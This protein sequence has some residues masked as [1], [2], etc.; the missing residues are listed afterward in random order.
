MQ[1]VNLRTYTSASMEFGI[2]NIDEAVEQ[3][4]EKPNEY[5]PSFAITEKNN[6]YSVI[7]FYKKSTSINPNFK[8]II[9]IDLD[10]SSEKKKSYDII[11]QGETRETFRKETEK[12]PLLLI[13]KN[14]N[15]YVNL[16]KLQTL[17]YKSQKR[18]RVSEEQA[19]KNKNLFK[20]LF[21]L[22]GGNTG[23]LFHSF[24]KFRKNIKEENVK[25]IEDHITFW[26][27]LTN[28][29]YFIELQRDGTKY[30]N[31]FIKFIIPIAIK[32][33]VPVV[34]T[35]NTYFNKKE[36]FELHELFMAHKDKDAKSVY[37]NKYRATNAT[38]ENYLKSNSEMIELFSDIPVA[39]KNTEHIFNQC[40]VKFELNKHNYLPEIKS[41]NPDENIE[42]YFE[43]LSNEGLEIILLK[44][45]EKYG[46]KQKC[47]ENGYI[48]S[49]Y[50]NK[51]EEWQ[52]LQL[53]KNFLSNTELL[54]IIKKTK[55]YKQY[56]ERLD[57][58]I[59][60][61]KQMQFPSY[62]L[63]VQDFIKWA[64]K[65]DIPVGAGRGSGAGSLVAYALS[66]T[67]LDP[68]QFNLLFERFLNPERVSMP[69]FDIDFSST[70]RDK[71]IEY[72]KNKYNKNGDVY[73]TAIMNVGKYDVKSAIDMAAKSFKINNTHPMIKSIKEL[74][75]VKDEDEKNT[76]DENLIEDEDDENILEN[77]FFKELKDNKVF[78]FKYYNNGLFRDII[79]TASKYYKNMRNVSK[80]AAG[81]VIS[82][83]PIDNIVPLVNID[84]SFLT[85]F[86]KDN[87]EAMGLIKFDF[88]GLENLHIMQ[89][90]LEE[91][92]K[93]NSEKIKI[94]DL[95]NI[96]IYDQNVYKNIYQNGNTH[97]VFQFSSESM[98]KYLKQMKPDTFEDLIAMV[99]L[100]RPG[101]MDIIP[102]Y[103]DTKKGLK[104]I[105]D[106]APSCP[107]V[108]EI[109]KET[110]GFI[111]YQEQIMQI[112]QVYAGYT[113]G[114]ADLLR[115]AMGKKKPEEMAKQREVFINGALKNCPEDMIEYKKNE[116]I[117]IFDLMEK[118]ASY[119]FNKSHAAAYAFVSFQTAYLKHYYPHEYMLAA[120]HSNQRNKK[121]SFVIEQSILDAYKNGVNIKNI[122]IN[123]SQDNFCLTQNKE[124]VVPITK[125]K[126]FNGDIAKQITSIKEKIRE[127]Y[128]I[129]ENEN[130]FSDMHH[131]LTLM[132]QNHCNISDKLL[133]NLLKIG[134]FSNI[135][136]GREKFLEINANNIIKHIKGN[137]V[138][139]KSELLKTLPSSLI[140]NSAK[141]KPKKLDLI[142]VKEQKTITEDLKNHYELI[143]FILDNEKLDLLSKIYENTLKLFNN[144]EITFFNIISN[145]NEIK[146]DLIEQLN[147]RKKEHL[148]RLASSKDKEVKFS[149]NGISNKKLIQGYI[150]EEIETK[151]GSIIFKVVSQ[152]EKFYIKTYD[153]VNLN[154]FENYI[155]HIESAI[156]NKS[157][158]DEDDIVYNFKLI[159]V[160]PLSN[161]SNQLFEKLKF[162]YNGVFNKNENTNIDEYILK[163]LEEHDLYKINEDG[164]EIILNNN[165]IEPIKIFLPESNK[166]I[167]I[168]IDEKFFNFLNESNLAINFEIKK[169]VLENNKINT[170][171]ISGNMKK[172][173]KFEEMEEKINNNKTFNE[174]IP[175]TKLSNAKI[176]DDEIPKNYTHLMYGYLKEVKIFKG[177][178]SN[179][180]FVDNLGNEI[181]KIKAIETL[182]QPEIKLYEP[183]IIKI[184][185]NRSKNNVNFLKMEDIYYEKNI[186]KLK[187][188]NNIKYI[189]SYDKEKLNNIIQKNNLIIEKKH[190]LDN[191]DNF[192]NNDDYLIIKYKNKNNTD[193]FIESYYHLIKVK[194]CKE[195]ILKELEQNEIF[196]AP[197]FYNDK[198]EINDVSLLSSYQK[199]PISE[200]SFY[201]TK[202]FEKDYNFNHL[203]LK[204][205]NVS[206]FTD[207]FVKTSNINDYG[208][209]MAKNKE[210]VMVCGLIAEYEENKNGIFFK[211]VDDT[212]NIS[213]KVDKEKEGKHFDFKYH[214]ENN[215]PLVFK[216]N[217]ST[218]NKVNNGIVYK[219]IIDIYTIENTLQT[220]V[221]NIYI[222]YDDKYNISFDEFYSDLD[223]LAKS[224]NIKNNMK[225]INIII[226]DKNNT[227]NKLSPIVTKFSLKLIE[228][229]KEKFKIDENNIYLKLN[230]NIKVI[231]PNLFPN[232]YENKFNQK[233]NPSLSYKR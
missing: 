178:I 110:Y 200:K 101:P 28:N 88:L 176:L 218:N 188:P 100:Y 11:E 228:K 229:I 225:N 99:S 131:F 164:T 97:N 130:V 9:G 5:Y 89:H 145:L 65:N 209:D 174:I 215:I 198:E 70:G 169:N 2:F 111:I 10:F 152:S 82:S 29:N 75:G 109:L 157:N 61:I 47:I 207:K 185:L 128:G 12:Y 32:L 197:L 232:N 161:I 150:A 20:D 34:A 26:K 139:V 227:G 51:F 195:L 116:A 86:N 189:M 21:V 183:C 43:R 191:I 163:K 105:V 155:F 54:E 158:I 22:S 148:E 74:V 210:R 147:N 206:K 136:K 81:I 140:K 184:N 117:A 64:K 208:I 167:P 112:A 50:F 149:I 132:Y 187:I 25:D 1:F 194:E 36:D 62:F 221:E 204:M 23:H 186:N 27:E 168:I 182:E 165:E 134:A 126:G 67:D 95:S 92:N 172:H 39:I 146:F 90:C 201:L 226:S 211:I 57:Y 173:I 222:K 179:I 162:K 159:D 196:F 143:G 78:Q 202:Y 122:D 144:N 142:D 205:N 115:R 175:Y 83:Q 72:V 170:N 30:E 49:E 108:A 124:I 93:N 129:E 119:G 53:D 203:Y 216:L 141:S 37:T 138:L 217:I 106:I 60:I 98:I 33:G 46:N 151:Y 125:I 190:L 13:A 120:L 66:I 15:G 35:N 231:N 180:T 133:I 45:L 214:A 213:I 4:I 7:D 177:K 42:E 230:N 212:G 18:D 85:Q 76:N 135:E 31:D 154:P 87:A 219:N 233:Y 192:I 59:N 17:F 58:E 199:N 68:L 181:S 193:E 8:P 52:E 55:V 69:D 91:I 3:S 41:P 24:L 153:K 38:P 71:V 223:E 96:N 137:Q 166:E 156:S 63:V 19:E 56:K 14:K 220:L 44:L 6:M 102:D 79:K 127:Q 123:F 160:Y 113:Y 48:N 77:D 40:D 103:I 121:E 224:N 80:H 114:Q 84:S 73:V 94:E 118:F 171:E 107:E 104:P 16:S